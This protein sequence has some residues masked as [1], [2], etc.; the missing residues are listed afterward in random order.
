MASLETQTMIGQ[1]LA[2]Y[3]IV[4]K[5]GAGGMGEVYRACD[6]RLDR[7]VAL[8]V[9]HRHLAATP[10]ARARFEREARTVSQLSHPHICTLHDV[11]SQGDVDYVVME[12]IRGESL[13]ERLQEG[14]LPLGELLPLGI[15]T[16]NALACA[17]DAGV[18][19]RD[20]KPGNLML[21][22]S[23]VK[24]L[25]FGL[26]R[27]SDPKDTGPDS[28]TQA[29]PL[30][31]AGAIIGTLQYMSP[32]QLAGHETDARTDIFAF[33]C[34]LHE[35]ATGRRAF[36][37]NDP[38]SI[39]ASILGTTAERI[40]ADVASLPRALADVI[41]RCLEKEPADR[42]AN[43]ED[44]ANDLTHIRDWARSE[45]LPALVKI[46]GQIQILD[47]GPETW[48][49]WELAQEIEQLAPGDHQLDVLWPEFTHPLRVM[50]DPPGAQVSVRN[51]GRPDDWIPLGTTPV[52]M[53]RAPRGCLCLKIEHPGYRTAHDLAWNHPYTDELGMDDRHYPLVGPGQ[54]P[55]E[56]EYVPAGAFTLFM[57]GLE[58]LEAQPTAAFLF[59]R[60][61]VTNKQYK[62]FVD[63]HGYAT[64]EFWQQPFTDAEREFSREEAMS[65]FTDSVG[66]PGPGAWELGEYPPGEDDHPVTG[67]SWFEAAA[68]AAWMGKS[69]P[70][71][72]HWN[73]TA[74]TFA[75]SQVVPRAN[76]AGQGTVP[77][78][79]TWCVNRFGVHDLAGNVREW[80][81][82][83][84]ARRSQ[85][86]ILGGG[87]NDPEYAF[88]DAY[89]QPAFDRSPT[90]GFRCICAVDPEPNEERLTAPI[91][92]PFRDFLA[93]TPV[94]DET[95]AFFRR[96]FLY[97]RTPLNDVIEAV[98]EGP[99]GRCQTVHLD[100][101]YGDERLIAYIFLP[102][103]G[104]AP[105]STVVI[106]PG[107]G[108]LQTTQV[109]PTEMRRVD[110]LLKSG[111]AV[112]LP[113]YKGTFQRHSEFKSDTPQDT[114]LY[115]DYLVM[116]AKDL[117]RT[118]DYLETRDD[119]D[120]ERLAYYGMSWGGAL[121]AIL[122]AVETR[123]QVVVLYVA[124]LHFQRPLP[125][126]DAINY[127]T[128]VTQP[129][130][131]LN[132]EFDFFFPKDSSQ[133]PMFELLGTADEH[134]KWLTFPGG[135]SV[136]RSAMI[137]EVLGWLEKY[138]GEGG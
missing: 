112:V 129:T 90:N 68:Y 12:L 126:A 96:Q 51:Y 86:F 60:H 3:K 72:H 30:T 99:L 83:E 69:L 73:R 133:R 7:D 31:T 8:K 117:S 107:S 54:I 21:T 17:H 97:D 34:I 55:D 94:G 110:F 19:H 123:I 76:L 1:T 75:S 58:H 53:E 109:G 105:Y 45:G 80:V 91:E 26:A 32:E 84:S 16:A 67:V 18:V 40:R 93:E 9:L 11:G 128:R 29:L 70:T 66:Q 124:G 102:P 138:L 59:D 78:G 132:G 35:M 108:A 82:N 92:L 120:T 36:D 42:F 52:E 71:L 56:M 4:E 39:M 23:G 15:Q 41:A 113:V 20:L 115:R 125:E 44:L 135:H 49:A 63:A 127:V 122:P 62:A 118:I 37:G 10:E 100:A 111:Y 104:R 106:F 33:G 48:N 22:E 81:W 64:P 13:A 116:W 65:R 28:A 50:S 57:P 6:T 98:E 136:P 27:P 38:A 47:E 131:M 121:G 85:R 87:W 2:H 79:T 95:F 25:D 137:Q 114:A 101:A 130:L 134:K 14:P 43:A 61:P 24:L 103:G 119:L 5:I 89:A 77:V 74:L 88:A 46:V